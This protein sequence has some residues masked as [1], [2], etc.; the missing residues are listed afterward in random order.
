L[1]PVL[2]GLG[3]LPAPLV[4]VAGVETV[5]RAGAGKRLRF[6]INHNEVA[7]RVKL[8]AGGRELISETNVTGEIELAVGEV[9]VVRE[10]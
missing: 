10:V 9:A 4:R 1:E 8:A 2:A 5:V 7:T 3:A 6:Y